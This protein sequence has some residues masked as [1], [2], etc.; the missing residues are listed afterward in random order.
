MCLVNPYLKQIV[1]AMAPINIH[2]EITHCEG[3]IKQKAQTDTTWWFIY[4]CS[5]FFR[6]TLRH[7]HTYVHSR[8][9]ARFCGAFSFCGK[10][11]YCY[12]LRHYGG[13]TIHNF[14]TRA[15]DR[16][17]NPFEHTLTDSHAQ[18]ICVCIA[19]FF[20]DMFLSFYLANQNSKA[21]SYVISSHHYKSDINANI[22]EP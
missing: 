15:L 20:A 7:T 12:H 22:F 13:H 8:I 9:Y 3:R 4:I 5:I 17:Q 18:I 11:I 16:K 2:T 14:V 6:P 1:R 10:L 21:S 19:I